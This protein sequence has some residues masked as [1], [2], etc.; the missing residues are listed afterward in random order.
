MIPWYVEQAPEALT[1]LTH[2]DYTR[3]KA[4]LKGALK[5]HV[6]D[7]AGGHYQGNGKSSAS[8]HLFNPRW[9]ILRTVIYEEYESVDALS[10]IPTNH[11]LDGLWEARRN[12][13]FT[14]EKS[15]KTYRFWNLS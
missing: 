11:Q 14:L 6:A 3:A 7:Y 4:G 8:Q 12:L 13:P 2:A 9:P 15:H 5:D 1:K 10:L